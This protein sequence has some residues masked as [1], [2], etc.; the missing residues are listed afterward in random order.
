[1]KGKM[2][3]LTGTGLFGKAP[4][5]RFKPGKEPVPGRKPNAP[6]AQRFTP[7]PLDKKGK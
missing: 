1:M 5:G 2:Y 6:L 4:R 3:K 7:S